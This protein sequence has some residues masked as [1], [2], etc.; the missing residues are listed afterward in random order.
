MTE[1]IKGPGGLVIELDEAQVFPSDPGSGT[2][3]L[4]TLKGSSSSFNCAYDTGFV[5]NEELTTA[6]AAFLES[7]ADELDIWLTEAV[8]K[9]KGNQ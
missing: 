5:D 2:P 3:I 8:R 4:V 6:Q 7:K 1:T 9:A